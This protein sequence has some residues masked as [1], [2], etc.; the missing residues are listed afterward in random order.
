[1]NYFKDVIYANFSNLAYLNWDGIK[2]G[3]YV[4]DALFDIR[5]KNT[6][7]LNTGSEH[8]FMVYSEDEKNESPLWD[9]DFNHWKFLYAADR[10]KLYTHKG[11]LKSGETIPSGTGF[12]AVA[13]INNR[14]IL[15]SFRGT[16]DI[17]DVL[18]DIQLSTGTMSFQ[19][20]YA[21]EFVKFIMRKYVGEY[22]SI[23]LT[24]HSL[25]GA[26]V[27]S[28]MNSDLNTKIS[29]AVTFNAFGIKDILDQW[30]TKMNDYC[31]VNCIGW[32]GLPNA[33]KIVKELK[34]LFKLNERT[35]A[36][37]GFISL[38][39]KLISIM[40]V[41]S[42]IKRSYDEYVRS[43]CSFNIVIEKDS[44]IFKNLKYQFGTVSSKPWLERKDDEE[45]GRNFVNKDTNGEIEGITIKSWLLFDMCNYLNAV[46]NNVDKSNRENIINYII[47][48]DCVGSWKPH[49][50][51]VVRVDTPDLDSSQVIG[52]VIPNLIEKSLAR[53][54][55]VGNFFM[56]MNDVGMFDG[57]VRKIV[58][59]NLI[60][61]Y[62]YSTSTSILDDIEI[63]SIAKKSLDLLFNLPI[64]LS[65]N[66]VI[67]ARYSFGYLYERLLQNYI[68]WEHDDVVTLG[69]YGN[70]KHDGI[71]FTKGAVDIKIV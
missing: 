2:T 65:M 26:L 52:A 71:D 6:R 58:L 13:F 68:L 38:N 1:M 12:Y 3:T 28:I 54:H 16:D 29:S 64:L 42:I 24:G 5:K 63:P 53:L 23:H 46:F 22:D 47:T 51:K 17:T 39:S 31:L 10:H 25:G 60:R 41:E 37:E 56:F 69:A 66:K 62:L 45:I 67:L 21:Y 55:T 59:T 8:I 32:M 15:I 9:D 14:D 70:L 7:K 35:V 4:K 18:A 48:K 27:Q 43:G 19:L 20:L 49:L 40:D 30:N 57:H 44:K 61:D 33:G 11:V 50:G 34:E 36:K